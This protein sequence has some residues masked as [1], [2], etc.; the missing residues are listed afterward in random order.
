VGEE[1]KDEGEEEKDEGEGVREE[2][3]ELGV[4]RVLLSVEQVTSAVLLH[5]RSS[6]TTSFFLR[7]FRLVFADSQFS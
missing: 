6:K 3:F 4:E 1:E 2:F 5:T 7:A